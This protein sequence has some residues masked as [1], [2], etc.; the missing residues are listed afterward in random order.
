MA[1][2]VLARPERRNAFSAAMLAD[3]ADAVE[4]VVSD[5]GVRAVALVSEGGAFSV[6]ADVYEFGDNLD[7]GSMTERVLGNVELMNPV[8]A[9]I[10][11][12]AVPTVAGIDGV[13][14]GAGLALA[15]AC[16]IRIGGPECSFIPAFVGVG[17]PPDSGASWLLERAVGRGQATDIL[18]RNRKVAAQEALALGLITQ[19][20]D[21]PR[22][23]AVAVAAELAS[24]PPTA[25]AATKQLARR[26]RDTLAERMT[27][28]RTALEASLATS[29]PAE[30]IRA[31][32]ERRAPAW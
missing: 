7:Q 20:V 14:A 25:L 32:L 23:R 1:V 13:A 27:A 28:E 2:V 30:G 6:G 15:L 12:L 21:E 26:P 8:V 17:I 22:V 5:P 11:D 31:F 16:D 19:L 29:E 3:L 9:A 24:G 4:N 10:V 18:L